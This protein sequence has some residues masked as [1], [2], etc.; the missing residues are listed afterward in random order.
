MRSKFILARKLGEKIAA[1]RKL[2]RTKVYQRYLFAPE[3]RLEVSFETGFKFEKDMYAD[4]GL[5]W[6]RGR[7]RFLKHF[8]GSDQVPAFD[9]NETGEEFK[10]AQ[11]IESLPEVKLWL[12]NVARHKRSF[13]LPTAT[14]NFYPDFVGELTDGRLFAVEYKGG[15]TAETFDATEK[16]TIGAAWEKAGEGKG[17]FLLAEKTIGGKDVRAQLS[18]KFKA[19][20]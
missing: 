4:A 17:L 18:A 19:Q 6:Y 12:R 3:A 5:T 13:R 1:A 9:G 10:C 11:A 14:D 8:L 20:G 15:L 2:E 7:F 16:R